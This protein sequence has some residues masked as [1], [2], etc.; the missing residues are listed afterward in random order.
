M[1]N[2]KLLSIVDRIVFIETKSGYRIKPIKFD[3][4]IVFEYYFFFDSLMIWLFAER[5]WPIDLCTSFVVTF[6]IKF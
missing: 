5:L 2:I 6:V 1:T 3:E 4:I